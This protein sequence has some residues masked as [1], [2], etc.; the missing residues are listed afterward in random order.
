MPCGLWLAP[1]TLEGAGIGIFAGRDYN[2]W[3][4]LQATGDIVIPIVDISIHNRNGF[5][6]PWTPPW[7]AYSWSSKVLHCDHEGSVKVNAFSTGFGAVVNSFLPLVNFRINFPRNDAAGLHRSRDPGAGAFTTYHDRFATAMNRKIRKGDELFIDY[8]ESW[9]KERPQL[10]PIPLFGDLEA[11]T[12]LYQSYQNLKT[13]LTNLSSEIA[14]DI[15]TTFVSETAFND[16]RVIGAF[17][18]G[19]TEEDFRLLKEYPTLTDVRIHQSRRSQDWFTKYG[20]CADHI[21]AGR[22]TIHQAGRGAFAT[23]N[24]PAGTVVAL[25]PLMHIVNRTRL[26]MYDLIQDSTGR[27][28]PDKEKGVTGHQ[29]LLSYSFG[30]NES[31][32]L[33][34]PYSPMVQ[35]VNH[36][37]TRVNVK[38]RWADPAR[39][40]HDPDLL[41][42]DPSQLDSDMTGKVAF[43]LVAISDI[44]EG[45]EVFLDYGDEFEATWQEHVKN[46]KPQPVDVNYTSAETMNARKRSGERLRTVFE[47]IKDPYPS[48]VEIKCH[49]A[50]LHTDR[51]K[52]AF[53]GTRKD[54]AAFLH[55]LNFRRS[56]FEC[57]ILRFE[58]IKGTTFYTAVL[59]GD[60]E[61]HLLENVP[62]EAFLFVDKPYST[63]IFLSRAFRRDIRIPDELFPAA[64]RNLKPRTD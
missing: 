15:W 33:L 52:K 46:W 8:G 30:H 17:R 45:D 20:T 36:N 61:N 42:A 14:H 19:N 23:R 4:H 53:Q 57:D 38:I 31:S 5:Q 63:D 2:E 56:I 1:S 34:L 39:S 10:G 26:D 21:R 41:T 37:Q 7:K 51:W 18:L 55:H 64:W 47:A 11:A 16:S 49:R 62:K 24:L 29:L 48:N 13:S 40:S 60:D 58:D 50:F 54:K 59:Y 22:S 44:Q 28:R 35:L 43:E 32:M 3:E 25:V 12:E 27:Y 9:F 6:G